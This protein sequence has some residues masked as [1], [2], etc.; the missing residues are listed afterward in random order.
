MI[1][2][3]HTQIGKAMIIIFIIAIFFVWGMGQVSPSE[4][5][6]IIWLLILFGFILSSFGT[7]QITV[8]SEYLKLKFGWGIFQKKFIQKDIISTA[9]VRNK[10][11]YGLG[12]K[13][14]LLPKKTILFA[15]SGLDAVEIQMKN[16]KIYRLGTDQPLKL[17][18]ALQ[19]NTKVELN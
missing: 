6:N 16:G 12:I 10:W 9:K 5:S 2:Y 13:F 3:R 14:L 1:I 7:L 15:V 8:N 11:Y 4:T 18:R 19:I 17:L